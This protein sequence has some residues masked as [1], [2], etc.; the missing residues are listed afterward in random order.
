MKKDS[1]IRRVSFAAVVGFAFIAVLLLA[2]PKFFVSSANGRQQVNSSKGHPNYDIRLD[3]KAADRMAEFRGRS[4]RSAV[5]VA[6]A[7]DEFVRG[8][9][10]LK[11]RVPS[12]KVEYGERLN[13]PEIIGLAP[14][15]NKSASLIGQASSSR[16]ESLRAFAKENASLVG[17]SN[18]Q[19]DKLTITSDYSNPDGELS[20][21]S[22]EQSVNGVPV[23]QGEI[24]A[25]FNKRG[26]MF[27]VINNLA[28]GLDEGSLS[29]DFGDAAQAVQTA[30]GNLGIKTG[31]IDLT[32]NASL[33]DDLKRTFGSGD[34]PTTAEK[35]YFP[36][37][38]G[39]AI[40]AWRVLIWE[41]SDAYYVI[42]DP[43]TG[44]ILWRKNITDDQT[45][46]ATY[47]VYA[48]TNNLGKALDSPSPGNPNPVFPGSP[49]PASIPS[50]QP[51]PVSRTNVTLIGNEGGLS[52][53][54]V[55][56]ITDNTNG[57]DGWTDG[58]AVQAGL[59][60]DGVNGV[61]APQ[62]G[63][64]RVF[65]FNYTPGAVTGAS[66]PPY[67][68]CTDVGDPVTGTAYRSGVVT[69]L[70]YL[71]NRYHDALYQV[72]FTEAARNFQNDNFGRGGV[73]GDRISAE[74][75][76]S[77]GTNNANFA[78]PAD[79]GRGRMQMYV[80][81]GA[82]PNRDGSLDANVVFHELT[83]GVS[84]RLIGNGG[85]LSSQQSGGMGEGWSDLFAFLLLSKT[86]DPA[87]GV[88]T[89]G[90]Y[91]T[92]RCCG[93]GTFTQNYFYGIRRFPYAAKTVTGGASNRPYNPLTFADIDP[94][95]LSATDGA[96]PC[97]SLIGC[98]GNASEVHN[99]G[100]LWAL[101]GVEVW[102]RFVTRLGHDAG[103]LRTLQLYTDGMKL[104]PLNPTF[105]QE[106]D[107]LIAAAQAGGSAADVVDIW[108]AFAARGMGFTATNPSGN[109]V[110]QA[111]DLPNIT[112]TAAITIN[113]ST[114]NGNGFPEPGELITI[115]VPFDNNTGQTATGVSFQLVGGASS[116][117]ASFP[118]GFQAI[119]QLQYIVPAAT[120]CGSTIN[121]TLN[122]N[123][124]L[125][126]VSFNRS[127]IIGAPS[128]T[129][130]QNFDSV[131]VPNLPSGWTSTSVLGG[132]NWVTVNTTADTAPNS[133]Y[134]VDTST[135]ASEADL[136]SPTMAINSTAA[137]VSF[138]HSYNTEAAW[139][140]GVLE[141][142]IG[143]GAFTD[144]ITAGGAFVSN[145]YNGTMTAATPTATYTPNPLQSRQGWTGNSNG[146]ITTV[147]R[148]P[149]SA[150]GQNVRL[151]FRMGSDD[152][153]AGAGANPGWN[154]DTIS[155]NGTYTCGV[156]N[157]VSRTPFDFDGDGK[158]DISIFRPNPGE[159]WYSRSTDGQVI[160]GAF[161]TSTDIPTPGD[162]TGD[163]KT[164]IAFFRPS[165]GQWFILRS[166][167]NSFF[168]FPFGSNGDIPMPADFDGD[169]KTDAAVFR[170]STATWFILPS[171]GGATIISQFGINGDQPVAADYDGDG[172][173]DIGVY[174]TNGAAKEWWV[175][176]STAGLF[177]TTFGTTGD[178]AVPGDY[179]GDGKADIAVFRPSSG[180][181]FVLR[182]EDNS[183]FS[184]PFGQNG[185][186]PVPA[187]Y[188]GDHKFDAAV[189]R[190]SST[191]WFVNRSGGLGTLIQN[192]GNSTDVPAP[193]A[194]VRQ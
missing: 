135:F 20:F 182:S 136:T 37:E 193:S 103:T 85:G 185:D 115:N 119:A 148:L 166:E 129:L 3:T 100:E 121:L 152:N 124:N 7:R 91:A 9:S 165:T 194:F 2:A 107:S 145:G 78:T 138:R 108:S 16:G 72:G 23:F 184:F 106:R 8:E 41:K 63:T 173:A 172:K 66:T 117:V 65:S 144:V 176:R 24:K 153:T 56:W 126:P 83:H 183:F 188:D 35:M 21:A 12:L 47:N 102:S 175:Q 55:G 17:V 143:G 33:S 120:P 167:D 171:A 82:T 154:I 30:A 96:F 53:N 45:Q 48:A 10:A 18:S 4:S 169:G 68:C 170:P 191:T 189:F 118:N 97:S 58:N 87:N 19:A 29:A 42:V 73:A 116:N 94:A 13:A 164:D 61:D 67:T 1:S 192:F 81:T 95:Q 159:W 59:D 62:N 74:A 147:V 79:G 123:S 32:E 27:R 34:W 109:T 131:T 89:T 174:R 64:G 99:E 60:I 22:L 36:T 142:S 177:A 113:D 163:G 160:A 178:M 168:A 52:F 105:L 151:K 70:F 51:E 15:Q 14:S 180:T 127:I 28:P 150:N 140:G 71:T 187:D 11:Q 112:Q 86:T 139:D 149:A 38:P 31:S 137:T 110:V 39:V 179:T 101:T 134:G 114:G 122:V 50:Y 125:G 104:S 88:Y 26:E 141:I 43:A 161:G 75:Q 130:A 25:G 155:V 162:F 128:Q 69:H 76:D 40:P 54:N 46:S 156:S 157:T 190:P 90:G 57:T 186:V 5:N 146:F 44:T 80:F 93:L 49:D 84:N 92:Y 132:I 181:W 77:S 111:F 6:D 158:A 133:I 98:S